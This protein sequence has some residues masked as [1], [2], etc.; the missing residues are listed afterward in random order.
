MKRGVDASCLCPRERTVRRDSDRNLSLFNSAGQ[1]GEM[2]QESVTQLAAT[3]NEL[4]EHIVQT[5]NPVC[6]QVAW[7][8][9]SHQGRPVA[10]RQGRAPCIFAKTRNI[11]DDTTETSY[12]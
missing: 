12:F 3:K 7:S 1:V 9:G 4:L 6:Q 8:A 2:V 10:S 5:V 11:F